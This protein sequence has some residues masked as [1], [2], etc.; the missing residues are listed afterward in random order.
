MYVYLSVKLFWSTPNYPKV[1]NLPSSG[2]IKQNESLTQLSG[3]TFLSKVP[4]SI[5]CFPTWISK[6]KSIKLLPPPHYLLPKAAPE[7]ILTN[8][9]YTHTHTHESIRNWYWPNGS[10]GRHWLNKPEE[11]RVFKTRVKVE[12]INRTELSPLVFLCTPWHMNTHR[13]TI[14]R[15]SNKI[16]I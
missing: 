3:F 9:Q 2:Q 14:H 6:V 13:H 11:L 7:V 12:G 4:Y 16:I 15:S 5:F 8:T 1:V 10:A